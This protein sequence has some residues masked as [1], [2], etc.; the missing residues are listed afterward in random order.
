VGPCMSWCERYDLGFSAGLDCRPPLWQ[1][2]WER[3]ASRPWSDVQQKVGRRTVSDTVRERK[4]GGEEE[5][6]D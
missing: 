3:A 5:K 4:R 2:G 6:G 1:G